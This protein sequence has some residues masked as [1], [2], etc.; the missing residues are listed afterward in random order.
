MELIFFI[1]FF[2]N[3]FYGRTEP[4]KKTFYQFFYPASVAE[5]SK[6][7]ISHQVENTVA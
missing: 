2:W 1:F 7:L 3:L 6:T 4:E 5:W